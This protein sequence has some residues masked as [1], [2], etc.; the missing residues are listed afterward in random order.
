MP[1]TQVTETLKVEPNHV[2]V[3][4]PAKHLA[5]VDGHIRLQEPERIRGKR[6]PID[7][8][9][10]T[11]GDAY[12]NH[13]VAV[14]LSGTGSDGT[15]GIKRVKENGGIV[16]AQSP[17][18]AEFNEMPRNAVN[19]KLVDVVLPVSELPE[20]ILAIGE[21][22][23][24]LEPLAETTDDVEPLDAP[25]E[26][27]AKTPSDP[28]REI[29]TVLKVLTGHDFSN[30]KRPTLLRRVARRLQVH[31]L[32]DMESYVTLLRENNDEAQAL[33]RDLLISVT[34]F[35]RDKEAFAALEQDI[36]PRLFVNKTSN[37]T[38]RV[39]SCGCATGEEAYSLAMLLSEYAGK[40]SDAP[41]IQIFAS[42]ISEEAI[43]VAREGRYDDS[44]VA[45]MSPERLQRFFV[46]DG[47]GYR[48]KKEIRDLVLF[49]PH[50]V[51][52]DPPFSRLELITC[53][54]LLIYLNRD[55]QEKIFEVFHFALRPNGFLFLGS[56][57][58]AE[59]VTNLF[60]ILDK[61]NRLYQYRPVPTPYTTLPMMPLPGKWEVKNIVDLKPLEQ[62]ASFG[63]LH[64]RLVEKLAPPSVL[65]DEN[66]DIVHLSESAGRF[67]QM[68]G[69]QPTH[70]LLKVIHPSLRLDL[71][72]VLLEAR[73]TGGPSEARN[74]RFADGEDIFLTLR[75]HGVK[76]SETAQGFY[77][78][79]FDPTT[80]P[81]APAK[82]LEAEQ[83]PRRDAVTSVVGHLEEDL[84]RTRD[85]LRATIEQHE[86]SVEELRASNEE[87]QAI[88]EELRS[89]SE[90]LETSKEELQSVNEEL[91]T[92]NHELKE[93]VD[94]LSRAN[95]D[96]QNLMASTD[97][98]TMFLDRAL[99]IKFYTPSVGD[100]F[101]IIPSDVERPLAHLT[102]KLD[103]PNLSNDA[104]EVLRTLQT[105][106]RE[107]KANDRH[108]LVRLTPYRTLEDRI[109]G[110]VISFVDVS[111]LTHTTEALRVSEHLSAQQTR[112]FDTS[113]AALT[114]FVYF[115]DKEGRFMYSNRPL[116]ELLGITL[117]DLIGKNFFDLNYPD[118]LAAR[119]QGQIQHVLTTGETVRD[120]TPFT[121]PKGEEGFYE[122]IFSPVLAP[123]GSVELVAGATR[124]V[125]ERNRTEQ[126]L[127]AKEAELDTIIN[128]TPFMLTRCT[129]DLRYRFVSPA[130]AAMI[131]RKPEDI[132]GRPIIEIMGEEGFKTIAPH[133][134]RVLQ[135]ERVEY[136]DEVDFRSDGAP[137]LHVVYTPDRDETGNV[138][139]W[140]ASIVDITERK[141]AEEALRTSQQALQQSD[142]RKD[143]FLAVLAHELRNPLSPIRTSLEIMKRTKNKEIDEEARAVIERQ[144]QHMVRLV[145]DS[146]IF[147]ASPEAKSPCKKNGLHFL[148]SYKWR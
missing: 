85:Q 20:K 23:K 134:E 118:E 16:L 39:W 75:V 53:R 86:T 146:W 51:L 88:N 48:V 54:N 12:G 33:L 67:L 37:D 21:V 76:T 104:S 129:R 101:N 93:K 144:V 139:G 125:T 8:F 59:S 38:V 82:S 55:T 17:N 60:N 36:I 109:E 79:I 58:S 113:L 91:I 84:S 3:I 96:L 105:V 111:E 99:N 63:D 147:H 14:I 35:F 1:V 112:T 69:G 10:R 61:K 97:I 137:Y 138:V 143:E 68:V 43:R 92:V 19:T 81:T 5:M 50:N 44:L 29:L 25:E 4:P 52:R 57:E 132:A 126:A 114:D 40:Q 78:V 87:L 47:K 136:E 128:H 64:F 28:L 124:D 100:L 65:V 123:D 42:D 62:A 89:A 6:V 13:A 133:V 141:L 72:S 49:A 83:A 45:D 66:Y 74:V 90:E 130:Y 9:F 7:L 41:K 56:S 131:H 32:T 106:E 11:L 98:G 145:D 30:Y 46:K 34:N 116:L 121:S 108:Y 115:F 94:D 77:L 26:P 110:V 27:K 135:G 122:Y 2:Y 117:E 148:K 71:R 103:Y 80:T 24:R 119:L 102:H 107:V 70:D 120:E 140:F 95:S 31:E 18:D 15:L 73:Q 142:K 127:L 22:A